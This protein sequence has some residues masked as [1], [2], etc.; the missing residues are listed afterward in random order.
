[1]TPFRLLILQ[2][3]S[4]RHG[5]AVRRC[6][7]TC[8]SGNLWF[9]RL[10]GSHDDERQATDLPKHLRQ[11]CGFVRGKDMVLVANPLSALR[12]HRASAYVPN[13]RSV[14]GRLRRLPRLSSFPFVLLLFPTQ[15]VA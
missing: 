5:L 6:C 7:R 14:I 1:V 10:E 2:K 12:N 15:R 9:T 11:S 4:S 3:H 13:T 8:T